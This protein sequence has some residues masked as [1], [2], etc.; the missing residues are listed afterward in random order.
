LKLTSKKVNAQRDRETVHSENC[1]IKFNP[2]LNSKGETIDFTMDIITE[3]RVY[4]LH[5]SDEEWKKKP[6]KARA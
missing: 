6:W 2:T 4:T 5:V 1:S 3:E